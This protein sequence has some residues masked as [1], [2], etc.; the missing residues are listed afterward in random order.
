MNGNGPGERMNG[1]A[2]FCAGLDETALF[3][4]CIWQSNK[5]KKSNDSIYKFNHQRGNSLI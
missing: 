2:I 5:H 1:I 4:M 3:C